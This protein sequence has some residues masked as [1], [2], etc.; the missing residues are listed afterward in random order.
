MN[1]SSILTVRNLKKSY[2]I[3]DVLRDVSF[4]LL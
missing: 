3:L 2:G 4:D 1:A